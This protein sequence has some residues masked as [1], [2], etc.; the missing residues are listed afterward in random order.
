MAVRQL[1]FYIGCWRSQRAALRRKKA[2]LLRQTHTHSPNFSKATDGGFIKKTG[3]KASALPFFYSGAKRLTRK[4]VF[5]LFKQKNKQISS[6]GAST[7]KLPVFLGQAKL[8]L[9]IPFRK[10]FVS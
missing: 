5:E 6:S 9:R 1:F 2:E 7:S 10:R 8:P 4:Q 3:G